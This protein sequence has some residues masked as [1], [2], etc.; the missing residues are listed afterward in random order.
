MR[1]DFKGSFCLVKKKQRNRN[2][3]PTP[4]KHKVIKV[5]NETFTTFDELILKLA[6]FS[7]FSGAMQI[8][9]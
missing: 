4:R 5:L 3:D 6:L 7:I 9:R 2:D 8:L 1:I